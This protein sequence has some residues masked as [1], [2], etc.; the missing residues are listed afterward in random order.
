MYFY[1]DDRPIHISYSKEFSRY[2][3]IFKTTENGN[4]VAKK[5]SLN[6]FE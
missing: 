2:F 5:V 3:C 4:V 1:G 6:N